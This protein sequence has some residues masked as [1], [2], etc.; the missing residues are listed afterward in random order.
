[1]THLDILVRNPTAADT[2][3]YE[4]IR[5]DISFTTIHGLAESIIGVNDHIREIDKRVND[6]DLILQNMPII[7]ERLSNDELLP[8][9]P[10][11]KLFD[12]L[13]AHA[14]VREGLKA[15]VREHWVLQE[16]VARRLAVMC[17]A[18]VEALD[19]PSLLDG[20]E[21]RAEGS[22]NPI[23]DS[24]IRDIVAHARQQSRRKDAPPLA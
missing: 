22:F 10:T 24:P 4:K 12:D 20:P 6:I 16:E 14:M 3:L 7:R 9:G 17:A 2:E 13:D 21:L 8:G 1:M 11:S 23:G 19:E 5:S 15:L 18:Y